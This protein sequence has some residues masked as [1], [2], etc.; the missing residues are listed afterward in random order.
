MRIISPTGDS[1]KAARYRVS[2]SVQRDGAA[3]RVNVRLLDARTGEQ[4]WSQRYERPFGDLFAVQSD[5]TRTLAE[6][7]L[8]RSLTVHETIELGA[9]IA[10]A[11]AVLHA[12]GILHR[13]VK[14]SNIGYTADGI[15]AYVLPP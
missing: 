2:G 12:A 13:D 4:L 1:I 9:N 8:R 5:I 11:L 6:Q 3:L 7:L 10:E 15:E 14:P